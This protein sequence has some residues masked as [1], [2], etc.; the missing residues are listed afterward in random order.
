MKRQ[1]TVQQPV[2]TGALTVL[3]VVM[4]I[5]LAALAV[6]SLTTAAADRKL[7]ARSGETTRATY[8]LELAGQQWLAQLDGAVVQAGGAEADPAAVQALTDGQLAGEVTW[9]GR[10]LRA[11]L[12][13]DGQRQLAL[14][15]TVLPGD[16]SR[17]RVDSWQILTPWESADPQGDLWDGQR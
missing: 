9:E 7:A 12:G 13:A 16:G 2:R 15:V 11:V 17:Y 10:T 5:C 1:G 4:S 8:A 6:L 14:A 3:L